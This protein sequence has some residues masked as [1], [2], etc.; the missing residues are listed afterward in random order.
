MSGHCPGMTAMGDSSAH[1]RPYDAVSVVLTLPT[2][3]SNSQMVVELGMSKYSPCFLN[4]A[5]ENFQKSSGA[6]RATCIDP[7]AYSA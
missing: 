5:S 1:L 7:F 3:A 4:S 2:M 6:A